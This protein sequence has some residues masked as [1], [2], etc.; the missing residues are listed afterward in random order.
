MGTLTVILLVVAAVFL[1]AAIGVSIDIY[2]WYLPKLARIFEERPFFVTEEGTPL[3]EAEPV[4]FNTHDGIVLEGSYWSTAAPR[5]QGVIVFCHEFLSNRWTA[6]QYCASLRDAGFDI[7]TFD[8]RN[9]GNSESLQGYDPLQW[10]TDYEVADVQAALAY[11]RQRSEGRITDIGLFG[12]SR[13]GSAAICAGALNPDVR[14]LATD[15]AFPTSGTQVH[16]IY[17]WARIYSPVHWL[18]VH[19]PRWYVRAMAWMTC[20]QVGRRRGCRFTSVERAMVRLD[21]RPVLMIHGERDNYIVPEIVQEF[22]RFTR[23]KAQLWV[24]PKAKHNQCLD[25]APEEY[26]KRIVEFFRRHL[27]SGTGSEEQQEAA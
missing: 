24:V 11:V 22:L 12:I 7:F 25:T 27:G 1:F 10:V 13:G 19:F 9:H 23:S 20:R 18:F 26:T 2:I 5:P 21:S 16:Y 17:R 8:F 4:R 6:T 3:S 15:G 14:A